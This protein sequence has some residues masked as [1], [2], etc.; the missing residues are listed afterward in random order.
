MKIILLSLLALAPAFAQAPKPWRAILAE[1]LNIYGHRN[2]I[3]IA[4]SAYPLQSSPGI[5][6]IL[7]S[8]NQVETVRHVFAALA[9]TPH[10]RPIVHI[11]R[12]LQYVTDE[13]AP[14]IGAYRQLVTGIFESS[15]PDQKPEAQF[16][17]QIIRQLDEAART[18]NVLVI[19]TNMA[20]PYTSVFIELRAGYWTDDAERRM[21][22]NMK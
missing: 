4:D 14:G 13:D 21:R 8:E 2:W 3:V 20:L 7:S 9:R 17:E 22:E 19:K 18:F 11:D 10:L 12:E 16:H 5:E 6:T 1:R 15:L